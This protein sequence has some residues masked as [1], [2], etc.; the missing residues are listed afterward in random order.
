M[1]K[2]TKLRGYREARNMTLRELAVELKI[3]HTTLFYWEVGKKKPKIGGRMKL[4]NYFGVPAEELI[5]PEGL[6]E[7]T[8]DKDKLVID[9]MEDTNTKEDTKDE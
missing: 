7:E 3:H 2:I 4:A 9:I 8:S 5:K 1:S 6:E